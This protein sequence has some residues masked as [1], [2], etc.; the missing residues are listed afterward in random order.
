MTSSGPEPHSP[1]SAGFSPL[2]DDQS[3][4]AGRHPPMPP[5]VSLAPGSPGTE[6]RK[7]LGIKTQFL[8][9]V[10]CFLK[11][12]LNLKVENITKITVQ[13][14]KFHWAVPPSAHGADWTVLPYPAA[15]FAQ[16]SAASPAAPSSPLAQV[17]GERPGPQPA[18]Q[19]QLFPQRVQHDWSG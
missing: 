18:V 17:A 16:N 10:Q 19:P 11:P 2:R 4:T 3:G 1:E 6:R 5:R 14:Y 15:V 8:K 12:S 13:H 9:N 7:T